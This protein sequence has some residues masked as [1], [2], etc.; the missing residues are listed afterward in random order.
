MN[1]NFS[2]MIRFL[3][4]LIA[5]FGMVLTASA[6]SNIRINNYWENTY[7]INPGA[8]ISE[9]QFVGSVAARKQWMNFPGA[10]MTEFMTFTAKLFTNRTH[11]T[12]IGQLGI[13]VFHDRIGYTDQVCISPSY[14]YSARLSLRWVLNMGIAYK[15]QNYFYDF[16]KATTETSFDPAIEN[17]RQ[18]WTE[19]N[20]DVGFELVSYNVLF[21]LSS[22]NIISLFV[23]DD[24]FESNTNFAYAM[25]KM[26]LDKTF[27][28]ASGLCLIN[29]KN[30]VQAEVKLAVM[31]E[32][33]RFP[34]V[35][36]GG[37]FRTK[38][39]FGLLMGM[40]LS[41]NLRL[42]LSYD[43]N[44]SGI[45]HSSSGTPEAQLIWKFGKV[46]N[47]ECEDFIR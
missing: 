13:K 10:P 2:L 5:G 30:I 8:V 20:A 3:A 21:G 15:V 23:P 42:A 19:N 22:V 33:H 26:K 39:E 11:A 4:L 7:Q 27:S 47:C 45:I 41:D 37:F 25:Y 6:Q 31:A 9:Y 35:E 36:I 28:F 12:Q 46:K 43:Y 34:D 16:Q 32:S 40:D 18:S 1:G 38:N 14:A 24:G 17:A 29:N 44:V